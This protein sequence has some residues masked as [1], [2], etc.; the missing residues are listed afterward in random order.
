MS[1]D[2]QVVALNRAEFVPLF[3][4]LHVHIAR[5]GCYACRIERSPVATA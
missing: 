5:P 3:A 2:F 1:I 4:Y